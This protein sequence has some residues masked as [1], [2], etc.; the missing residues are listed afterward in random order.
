MIRTY[1]P[2]PSAWPPWR[3]YFPADCSAPSRPR[4]PDSRSSPCSNC[5]CSPTA[6]PCGCSAPAP[7]PTKTNKKSNSEPIVPRNLTRTSHKTFKRSHTSEGRWRRSR[8]LSAER[9]RVTCWVAALAIFGQVVLSA[10]THADQDE[11]NGQLCDIPVCRMIS[12]NSRW[13]AA[14]FLEPGC[15]SE[16]HKAGGGLRTLTLRPYP[17]IESMNEIVNSL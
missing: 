10:R 11:I 9:L 15:M 13:G 12:W 3:H 4:S 8:S 2:F 7:F 16:L 14:H 1:F 17:A 5:C 6:S